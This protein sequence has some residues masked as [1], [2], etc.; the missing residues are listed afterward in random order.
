M[1]YDVTFSA[2]RVSV[3]LKET[4]PLPEDRRAFLGATVSLQSRERLDRL[5]TLIREFLDGLVD[6][7][8]P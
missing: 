5:G 6:P 1:D 8:N 2:D 3:T 7:P 4:L